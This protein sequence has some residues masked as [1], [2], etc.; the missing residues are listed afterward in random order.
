MLA[1]GNSTAT[2]LAFQFGNFS[3][4]FTNRLDNNTGIYATGYVFEKGAFG[5]LT[6]INGLHR[7]GKDIG[8][9]VWTRFQDPRYG[10]DLELK[11][12][13]AC[14]DNSSIGSGMQADYTEGFVIS[15][16]V[17]TPVAYN[18]DDNTGIYKYEL[19]EDNTV[20]SGSGSYV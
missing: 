11:V 17:A 10:M 7:E 16:D 13:K 9:D 12:K 20:L 15:V 4:D 14:A 1:Q 3:A 2:D 18:S 5:F 6:W 19:N 8:T